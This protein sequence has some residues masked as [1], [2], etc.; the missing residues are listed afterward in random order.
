MMKQLLLSFILT[1]GFAAGLAMPASAQDNP[2]TVQTDQSEED[3]RKSK[4]KTST[5]DPWNGFQNTNGWGQGTQR[6]LS[7]VDRL[8]E[9]SRRFLMK[10]RAER[11]AQ[12]GVG[13]PVDTS[14]KPSNEAKSDPSLESDEKAA[15]SE[16]M[17]D[18]GG[19]PSAGDPNGDPNGQGGG[20]P[21][22]PTQIGERGGSSGGVG[23]PQSSIMRG[24]SSASVS[25]I[26]AQIKGGGAAPIAQPQGQNLQGQV[27]LG[28]ASQG[29]APTAAQL[30]A[31]G[32]AQGQNQTQSKADSQNVSQN[33][34][35][36]QAQAEAQ[37][38]AQAAAQAQSDAAAQAAADAQASRTP[39]AISP[40]DRLKQTRQERESSGKRSSASDYLNRGN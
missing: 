35:D 6:T 33:A 1:S 13:E 15:W 36:G 7:P 11:L 16:M 19:M 28:Q 3:W 26:L 12:A 22:I 4:K 23:S 20:A 2:N 29:Q 18:M 27:P 21:Q 24:G 9:D 25:D 37:A 8:P 10:E 14:Y 32:L 40:L 34:A 31:Q 17:K 5:D 38:S 30:Q 39:E